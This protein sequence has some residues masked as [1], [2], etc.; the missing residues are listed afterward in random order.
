MHRT[1]LFLGFFLLSLFQVAYGQDFDDADRRHLL[2]EWVK[3]TRLPSGIISV[4]TLKKATAFSASE[5][6]V[7]LTFLDLDGNGRE[8][9]AIQSLC[10]TVGNCSLDIYKKTGRN[11]RT[12]LAT[13]MVQTIKLLPGRHG[14]YKDLKLGTHDSGY[15]T[16]YR[17]FRYSGRHYKRL[18][19]WTESY[20]YVDESGNGHE[21]KKPI[22]KS[23]CD[24]G[25]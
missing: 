6:Y 1:L 12:I 17:L 19:C 13:D 22:I 5:T 9:L 3:G 15:D 10:A 2:R 25:D 4:R 11:Y 24:S 7:N 18:R 21:L 20:Y 8:G 14:K 23:R 16:Y